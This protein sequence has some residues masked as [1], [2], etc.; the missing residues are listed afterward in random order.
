MITESQKPHLANYA[1]R[2]HFAD[3][4]MPE[5]EFIAACEAPCPAAPE[6]MT[7][8][9]VSLTTCN[10]SLARRSA[11]STGPGIEPHEAYLRHG[12]NSWNIASPP[13]PTFSLRVDTTG[14]KK[15]RMS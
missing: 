1:D 4:E 9:L 10:C 15:I 2:N 11:S 8:S 6:V 12:S 13:P 5:A 14:P 7:R 3:V